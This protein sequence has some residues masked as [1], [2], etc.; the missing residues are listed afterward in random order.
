MEI[1]NFSNSFFNLVAGLNRWP[2][3]VQVVKRDGIGS[4]SGSSGN[5]NEFSA[6]MPTLRSPRIT[7][8]RKA[9]RNRSDKTLKDTGPDSLH[10]RE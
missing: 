10:G 5:A 8:K 6:V 1:N 7:K 2:S 4:P 9:P 3:I